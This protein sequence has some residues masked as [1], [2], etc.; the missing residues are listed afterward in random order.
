MRI[1][2]PNLI[3]LIP[4]SGNGERPRGHLFEARCYSPGN[5]L[6]NDYTYEEKGYVYKSLGFLTLGQARLE[7]GTAKLFTP[8][9]KFT[10]CEQCIKSQFTR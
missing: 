10:L 8:G 5:E 9:G 3:Y 6:S 2:N 1:P 7:L 4:C